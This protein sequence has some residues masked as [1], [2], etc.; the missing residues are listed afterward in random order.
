VCRRPGGHVR[1]PACTDRRHPRACFLDELQAEC[2]R[3]LREELQCFSSAGL[4]DSV[5]LGSLQ[6]QRDAVR[7]REQRCYFGQLPPPRARSSW[8]IGASEIARFPRQRRGGPR[9]AQ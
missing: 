4:R 9:H 6:Q 7:L 5:V 8:R 1:R 3:L 2:E